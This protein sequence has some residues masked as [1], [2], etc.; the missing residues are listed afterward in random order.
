MKSRNLLSTLVMLL[1]SLF[2]IANNI[3]AQESDQAENP[4]IVHQIPTIP[5]I[6]DGI[7]MPP[8][9]IKKFDGQP[10]YTVVD[11]QTESEN[12]LYIYTTLDEVNKHVELSVQKDES[13]EDV[14]ASCYVHSR[15]YINTSYGGNYLSLQPGDGVSLKYDPYA[16]FDNNIESVKTTSCNVYSVLYEGYFY[17]GGSQLWLLNN[18]NI[19]DLS[20]YGW[21]NRASYVKIDP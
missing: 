1:I 17:I 21:A 2:I 3:S 12:V 18:R 11:N 13:L 16:L 10:L 7:K 9:D 19:S 5:I 6:V 20:I 8:E 15:F 4:P 14:K